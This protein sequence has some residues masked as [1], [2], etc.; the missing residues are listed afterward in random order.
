LITPKH[1]VRVN[2]EWKYPCQL[3]E[4]KLVNCSA[5]YTF[6]LESEHVMIINGIE[7]ITLGKTFDGKVKHD[8]FGTEAVVNDLMKLEGWNYGDIVL[9]DND[10]KR[11]GEANR[12]GGITSALK[13]VE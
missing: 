8:Y 4:K 7:C 5:V 3:G 1:P 6:V 9:N 2:G 13:L 12:V 11:G 10:M